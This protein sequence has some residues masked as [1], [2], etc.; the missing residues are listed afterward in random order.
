MQGSH[1]EITSRWNGPGTYRIRVAGHLDDQWASR[2]AGMAITVDAARGAEVI[3]TLI[4]GLRDQTE[5]AGVLNTLYEFHLR[6]L[7]VE[8]LADGGA[9][10]DP[11][12][13]RQP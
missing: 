2:L 4:G 7:M 1:R 11:S 13:G 10:G 8:L 12:G 6:I 5:L 9:A 3:T